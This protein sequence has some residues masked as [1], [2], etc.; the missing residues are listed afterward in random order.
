MQLATASSAPPFPTPLPKALPRP[1]PSASSSSSARLRA[2]SVSGPELAS[3]GFAVRRD[4][5]AS[6]V[7]PITTVRRA[8]SASPRR[9][10]R[11]LPPRPSAAG[12]AGGAVVWSARQP[13]RSGGAPGAFAERRR[14]RL[15]QRG[16][17]S[18]V[19]NPSQPGLA[20][21]ALVGS[22]S[23]RA[24]AARRRQTSRSTPSPASSA[25]YRPLGS[26]RTPTGSAHGL[27][28]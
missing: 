7:A 16:V 1:A 3:R 4:A 28:P 10:P 6:D 5:E 26:P 9:D 15:F 20:E 14:G 13:S 19:W 25:L 23:W 8:G 17:W 22:A 21:A 18:V 24:T 2:A 12:G 27:L 11:A